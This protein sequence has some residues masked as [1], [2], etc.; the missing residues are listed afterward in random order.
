MSLDVHCVW[1]LQVLVGLRL[2]LDWLR[3]RFLRLTGVEIVVLLL[4]TTSLAVLLLQWS[5]SLRADVQ[6]SL[7]RLDS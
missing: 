2:R 3:A 6:A 1:I 4:E 7:M 5:E